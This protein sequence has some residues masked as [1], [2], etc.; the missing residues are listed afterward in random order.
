VTRPTGAPARA[1]PDGAEQEDVVWTTQVLTDDDAF[2]PLKQDWEDLYRRCPAA[3]PFQ[4]YAWLESWWHEYGRPSGRLRL[5]LV[6]AGGRLAAAAPLVLERR[7]PWSVLTPIGGDESDF[8]DVLIDPQMAARAA[9]E[10][11]AAVA[12]IRGWSVLDIREV[13]SDAYVHQLAASWPGVRWRTRGAAGF[14]IPAGSVAEFLAVL[15]RSARKKIRGKL[16]KIDACGIEAHAVTAGELPDAVRG[17]LR[18][19]EQQWRGRAVNPEHLRDRYRRHLTRALG[20][21]IQQQQ[22]ALTQYRLDGELVVSDV[23]L[24][25]PGFVGKYLAGFQ[26]RMRQHVDVALM[27]LCQAL[28]LAERSRRPAVS[29]LRGD[30]PYKQ[31][32]HPT[33]FRSQRLLLACADSRLRAA[34]YAMLIRGRTSVADLV[35]RRV[36]WLRSLRAQARAVIRLKRAPR[37]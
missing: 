20:P 36:P 19:H 22:A 30:E 16:R 7:G 21:M 29:L 23:S 37:R 34:G 13:R 28:R 35:K 1:R 11:A 18:L 31:R 4:S 32:W 14:E 9:G 2:G 6:R 26:P 5:V 15:P 12:A 25:A 24:I 3:T 33:P 27:M 17:L 8:H 10:L